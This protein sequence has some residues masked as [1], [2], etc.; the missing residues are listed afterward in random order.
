MQEIY[1]KVILYVHFLKDR[2]DIA[3]SFVSFRHSN[4]ERAELCVFRKS[5]SKR[6]G[7]ICVGYRIS[8]D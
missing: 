8:H 1:C 7:N 5:I 2:K 4:I 3:E 6:N